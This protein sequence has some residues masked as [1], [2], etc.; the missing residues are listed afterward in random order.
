MH[1]RATLQGFVLAKATERPIEQP[2]KQAQRALRRVAVVTLSVMFGIEA[3]RCALPSSSGLALKVL[4]GLAHS[5]G[6]MAATLCSSLAVVSSMHD[7]GVDSDYLNDN[8]ELLR[9]CR[10]F[11]FIVAGNAAFVSSLTMAH[12][13]L[14]ATSESEMSSSAQSHIY[15]GLALYA[16]A[17]VAPAFGQ[18][19][20]ASLLYNKAQ[21]LY[22]QELGDESGELDG[23]YYAD[24]EARQMARNDRRGTVLAYTGMAAFALV[25]WCEIDNDQPSYILP[26][27]IVSTLLNYF[28]SRP[29][30]SSHEYCDSNEFCGFKIG[31][32]K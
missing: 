20:K 17:L 29:T 3:W 31:T 19:R 9:R 12:Q 25:K 18:W 4:S 27:L 32:V 7:V 30:Q 6:L 26:I 2:V 21:L 23:W 1:G 24:V 8:L 14:M 13:T 28:A 11:F 10:V 15:G 5:F 16:L 22:K